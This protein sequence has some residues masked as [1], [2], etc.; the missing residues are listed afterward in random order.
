MTIGFAARE[1]ALLAAAFT[2][3]SS[4][5][6]SAVITIVSPSFNQNISLIK[7]SE[8]FPNSYSYSFAIL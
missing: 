1:K 4:D 6:V 3:L 2:T 5:S 7:I 8:D